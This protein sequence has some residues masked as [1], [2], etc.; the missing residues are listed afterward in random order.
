[1]RQ[2]IYTSA[3]VLGLGAFS[4][5]QGV[6]FSEIEGSSSSSSTSTSTSTSSVEKHSNNENSTTY[7]F[8]FSDQT[9]LGIGPNNIIQLTNLGVNNNRH[10]DLAF[11][12]GFV[13]PFSGNY[14]VSYRVLVNSQASVALYKNG[15]LIPESAFANTSTSPIIGS[16]IVALK[17][18]D[19]VTIQS[20]ETAKTFNTMIPVSTSTPTVPVSLTVHYLDN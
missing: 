14:L 9:Q 18:H 16:L 7:A 5:I 3:I 12:G 6:D 1:M 2:M 8:Y 17:K 4:T 13:V 20:I 11:N 15:R 19:I 10:F